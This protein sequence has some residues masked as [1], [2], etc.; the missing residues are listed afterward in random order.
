MNSNSESEA[1]WN[2]NQALIWSERADEVAPKFLDNKELLD[3]HKRRLY[4][5]SPNLYPQFASYG[6]SEENWYYVNNEIIKYKDGKR[7]KE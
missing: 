1:I 5:K 4:S 3:S 6:I 7:I 2:Y